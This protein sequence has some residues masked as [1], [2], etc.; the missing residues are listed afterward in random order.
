VFREF[1]AHVK[2]HAGA[3]FATREEIAEWYLANH[4]SHI[5]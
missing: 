3:W 1:V 5:G 4:A 2:R